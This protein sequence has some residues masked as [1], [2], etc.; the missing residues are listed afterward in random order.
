M[1]YDSHIPYQGNKEKRCM[2]GGSGIQTDT[3]L[4]L[5]GGVK[6]SHLQKTHWMEKQEKII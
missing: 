6:L 5:T 4:I 3:Q 2:A 1:E